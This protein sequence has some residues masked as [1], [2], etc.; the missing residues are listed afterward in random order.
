VTDR[1]GTRGPVPPN[2]LR[3]LVLQGHHRQHR[4][5][6]G[7]VGHRREQRLPGGD[8]RGKAHLTAG[9]DDVLMAA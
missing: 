3:F 7:R 1:P 9:L 5:P 6:E 2:L 8:R 4:S